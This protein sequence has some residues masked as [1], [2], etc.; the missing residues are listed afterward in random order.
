MSITSTMVVNAVCVAAALQ[1]GL[2]LPSPWPVL[3]IMNE[4]KMEFWPKFYIYAS[5]PVLTCSK[6]YD[7]IK[8]SQLVDDCAAALCPLHLTKPS[9][10]FHQGCHCQ[11]DKPLL[12]N[13]KK[14]PKNTILQ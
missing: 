9:L 2:L 3:R 12:T 11:S 5:V 10:S 1:P 6:H 4:R 13:Y 14:N 8:L 7:F